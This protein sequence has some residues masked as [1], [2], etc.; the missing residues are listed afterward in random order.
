[1]SNPYFRSRLPSLNNYKLQFLWRSDAEESSP[2][3]GEKVGCRRPQ[4]R[5][6]PC[7]Q[8]VWFQFKFLGMPSPLI[9]ILVTFVFAP[10]YIRPYADSRKVENRLFL[11]ASSIQEASILSCTLQLL[12]KGRFI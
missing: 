9:F 1:M 11:E 2:N 10:L 12:S 8:P 3:T 6:Q 5:V 4:K 7:S